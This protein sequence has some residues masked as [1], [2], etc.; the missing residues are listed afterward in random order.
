MEIF[1]VCVFGIGT[2]KSLALCVHT[3]VIVHHFC[4]YLTLL[5]ELCNTMAVFTVCIKMH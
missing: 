5:Q 1:K 4:A 2:K 3:V